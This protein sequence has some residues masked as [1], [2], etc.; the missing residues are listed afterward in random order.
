MSEIPSSSGPSSVDALHAHEQPLLVW[1]CDTSGHCSGVND[2]WLHWRGG[3]RQDEAGQEW[4]DVVHPD[5]AAAA[6]RAGYGDCIASRK[7]FSMEV[8]VRRASGAYGRLL[9]AGTPICRGDGA[10]DG[11]VLTC[12]DVTDVPTTRRWWTKADDLLLAVTAEIDHGLTAQ[13]EA[14]LEPAGAASADERPGGH[15]TLVGTARGAAMHRLAHFIE[16]TELGQSDP[17]AGSAARQPT[18]AGHDVG[19]EAL[20][21]GRSAPTYP[22]RAGSHVAVAL[23]GVDAEPVEGAAADDWHAEEAMRI[24]ITRARRSVRQGDVVVQ[25]HRDQV[26]VILNQVTGLEPAIVVAA[27]VQAAIA[28]PMWLF[29]REVTPRVRIGVTLLEPDETM[30][31]GLLRAQAGLLEAQDPAAAD[32]VGL[33]LDGSGVRTG[34]HAMHRAS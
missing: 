14:Y 27:T 20:G 25:V 33:T 26:G 31:E 12:L 7:P 24:A 11:Y 16:T 15:L 2:A 19:A 30:S 4:L 17:E 13:K 29:G 22:S 9:A 18:R 23:I 1:V 32:V 3:T 6:L 21:G 5:D 28:R 10:P 8:R 34:T